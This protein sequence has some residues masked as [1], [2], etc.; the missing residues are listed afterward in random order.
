MAEEKKYLLAKLFNALNSPKT[1]RAV[2]VAGAFMVGGMLGSQHN[3]Y[4]LYRDIDTAFDA[5]T[6]GGESAQPVRLHAQGV[7]MTGPVWK[8]YLYETGPEGEAALTNV[9]CHEAFLKVTGN[10]SRLPWFAAN[11]WTVTSFDDGKPKTGRR[12]CV[13]MDGTK[14]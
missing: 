6:R 3:A 13:R 9:R 1:A 14:P 2:A 7:E 10:D 5:A 8:G 11:R 12:L 4:K